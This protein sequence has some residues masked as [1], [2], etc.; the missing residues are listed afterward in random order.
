MLYTTL[1]FTTLRYIQRHYTRQKLQLQIQLQLRLIQR[2]YTLTTLQYTTPHYT[3]PHHTTPH[4]TTLTTTAAT[5]TTTLLY[6]PLH[7]TKLHY[8]RLLDTTLIALHHNYSHTA[9][10]LQLQIRYTTLHP[11]V[12]G[13]VTNQVD[14]C[15]HCKHFWN[16]TPTTF[17]SICPSV[18]HNNQP[19]L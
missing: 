11:T 17:R 6:T 18:I 7:L 16:T 1:H 5:T 19:L 10:Q 13:E 4:Y 14:R 9:L 8:P 15:N 2:H 12:L 3:T